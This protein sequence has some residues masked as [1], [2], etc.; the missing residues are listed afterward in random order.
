MGALAEFERSLIIERTRAGVAA[1]RKRGQ[2]LG[3]RK[4]LTP[5]QVA[6]ARATNAEGKKTTAA[7]AVLLGISRA[8]LWRA[9]KQ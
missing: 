5:A 3:R 1:A 7:M 2:H 8:T 9:L 6:H 4:S